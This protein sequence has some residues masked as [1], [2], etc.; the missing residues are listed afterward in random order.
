MSA[1][2]GGG[3]PGGGYGGDGKVARDGHDGGGL[4][5]G[6]HYLGA[7]LRTVSRSYIPF[8][9]D[10]GLKLLV[11]LTLQDHI[12]YRLSMRCLNQMKP[13]IFTS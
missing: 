5:R 10:N 8:S 3:P 13:T 4:A 11:I 1:S 12:V 2:C 9:V 6:D 7:T